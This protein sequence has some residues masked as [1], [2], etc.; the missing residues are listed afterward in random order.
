MSKTPLFDI[1]I[2]VH[3]KDLAVLEY[4][5]EA[6][7]EKIVGVRRIITVSKERY[8]NNAEWFP[9]AQFPFT[10]DFVREYTAGSCGWYFQ[11]L[12]KLYAPF[13]IPDISENVLILDSDTVFFRKTKMFDAQ[14]RPFY[15]ISKDTKICRKPFDIAVEEHIQKLW[16]SISR[17]NLPLEFKE[18]S[19]ICH[20]M[21]FQRK[22]LEELFAEV[23]K[24]DGTG[25]KFYKIFLKLANHEH[26]VSEYQ[27]YFNFLL[28]YHR[29]KIAIRKLKY[30]NTADL[31]IRKYRKRL[32]YS[33]CSFHS[34]L[35][36]TRGTS[37]RIKIE[38]FCIKLFT[39][40]F[41][42]EVWNIGIARCNISEFVNI[43]NQE[44][45]W[46]KS[47]PLNEFRADSF[48][49]VRGNKKYIFFEKY[50]RQK[51]KGK[52]SLCELDD[53][54]EVVRQKD[55]LDDKN[56]LS[57]PYI[58]KHKNKDYALVEAHR[59]RELALYE[60]TQ[61][62][63]FKKIKTLFENSDIVDPSI[64]FH[65]NKFWLFFTKASKGDSELYLAYADELL[66]EWKM[67]PK[68]PVKNDIFS[69]RP[70]GEIFMHKSELYRPAQNC[71]KTYGGAIKIN[72]ILKL[73]T[74]E[75]QEAI[76][77]EVAPNQ[78]GSYP[79][80]LHTISSLGDDLTLID[81][82][83]KFFVVHKPLIHLF[84]ALR[85]IFNKIGR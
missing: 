41:I 6:A 20:S 81:G 7:R 77:I 34:Y 84:R 4:C 51:R 55:I 22:M 30:K 14:N 53:K 23:E 5:I 73:T 60:I 71:S 85:K 52:I 45:K 65:E 33:Y 56:H 80:G 1:V 13:V 15:N 78:L 31:N 11:Q 82:K 47:P 9:E 59:A 21:M 19:G 8:T 26:S 69:S 79:L 50:E 54:L 29:E 58:F 10:M 28:I 67:H 18:I 36:N 76:E 2:P 24:Y 12:L 75:F 37:W 44:I 57:Y 32:K 49:L 62:L 70:A 27:I 25:D 39:K 72:K 38:E 3:K 74:E 46:L 35:R 61:G 64:I 43:P 17:K 42:K 48:G 63:E 66:G 40:I 16:P 83:K 68:N